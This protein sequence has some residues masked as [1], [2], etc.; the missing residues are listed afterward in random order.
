MVAP[1]ILFAVTNP[2]G[3]GAPASIDQVPI[4][5]GTSET[6]DVDTIQTFGDDLSAIET[7]FTR[8]P[9]VDLAA[10]ALSCGIPSI[11]LCRVTGSV[12]AIIS[13]VT[14]TGAGGTLAVTGTASEELDCKVEITLGGAGGVAKFKYTLDD[15]A[16]SGVEPT[17]SEEILVPSGLTYTPPGTA[18]VLTFDV[19]PTVLVAGDT[20][21]FTTTPA[22]YGATQVTDLT[23]DVQSVDSGDATLM[24]YSG[25]AATA[26]AAATIGTTIASQLDTLFSKAYFLGAV[27]GAG[28]GTAAE[29]IT[30]T[31]SQ[32][33][34][35]PFGGPLYGFVYVTSPVARPGRGTL[36][37]G[38]HELAGVRI[39]LSQISTS[40]ARTASGPLKK[41]TGASYDAR[42]QGSALY[43]ARIG[44]PVTYQ[45]RLSGGVFLQG[46]KLF[47]APVG[48]F[49]DWPD[50][51][52]MIAALRAAHPVAWLQ[53]EEL[54]RTNANG[55]MDARDRADLKSA[56]MRAL[57]QSLV[58]PLN[59]RGFPGHVS[60]VNAT[61]VSTTVLPNV[62][63][64]IAIR[65]LGYGKFINFTLRY[66]GEV[67]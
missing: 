16:A 53:I 6:G 23:D 35:V 10:Y 17:W 63:V 1:R 27:F 24:V 67:A 34:T 65:R 59:V 57:S 48:D 58:E 39:A 7:E 26:A 36:A 45:P 12:A 33:W 31:A 5:I 8:G 60:E 29:F 41:A 56:V 40:P 4:F 20:Y 28:R 54:Y 21:E 61:V 2:G 11:K 22:Y 51:A 30:A 47:D 13:A 32:A 15:F 38:A 55:T 14:Q 62:D 64:Q 46:V 44:A 50:A 9:L 66:A 49:K 42:L 37:L 25:H 19:D 18:L 52:V 43:D 3:S